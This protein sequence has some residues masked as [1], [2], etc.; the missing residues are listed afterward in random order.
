MRRKFEVYAVAEDFD[1][2]EKEDWVVF[3]DLYGCSEDDAPKRMDEQLVF[4]ATQMKID[5]T[6]V[7]KSERRRLKS[8]RQPWP[9]NVKFNITLEM[10]LGSNRGI[11]EVTARRK[12]TSLGNVVLEYEKGTACSGSLT[13]E[14]R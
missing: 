2:E 6:P 12:N 7:V 14:G 11:L 4:T 3:Q 10:R 8:E 13:E 1:D 5:L 9:E